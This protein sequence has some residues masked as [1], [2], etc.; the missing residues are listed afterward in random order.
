[1]NYIFMFHFLPPPQ[2]LCCPQF[3][4]SETVGGRCVL[5][6]LDEQLSLSGAFDC[7]KV[8]LVL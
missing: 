2:K 5:L 3:T 1:M 8:K 6:V 4:A 7:K